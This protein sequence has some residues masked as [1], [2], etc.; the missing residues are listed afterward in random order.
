MQQLPPLVGIDPRTQRQIAIQV[1]YHDQRYL[2]I[3]KP[4]DL[5]IDGAVE[6]G[7]SVEQILNEKFAQ[8]RNISKLYLVHQLDAITSGV[9]LWALSSKVCSTG[10]FVV[11]YW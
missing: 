7:L 5:R 11:T 6:D 10:E 8:P 4:H 9:H 2:V 1:L 3:C